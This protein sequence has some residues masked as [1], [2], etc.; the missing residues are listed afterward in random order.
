D[1]VGDDDHQHREDGDGQKQLDER[2]SADTCRPEISRRQPAAA[3][4]EKWEGAGHDST[5][6]GDVGV[7]GGVFRA[8]FGLEVEASVRGGGD[9]DDDFAQELFRQ[10]T[11][12]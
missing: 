11:G 2:E 8:V 7:K 4:D 6:L 10:T 12:G 1:D 5:D 3:G 9:L